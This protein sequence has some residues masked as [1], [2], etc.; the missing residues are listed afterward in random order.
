MA[1]PKPF[2]INVPQE[3]IDRLKQKLALADFPDE[4]DQSGWDLGSP[5]ADIKKLT[6]AW[7]G[8]DWRAAEKK[9]NEFPQFHTD[10]EVDGFGTLDIHFVHRK[11]EDKDAIPLLF[12]HGWPGSFIEVLKILPLLTKTPSSN[13][14]SFHVVAP[15]LPNYGFSQG[16][17]KRG[18]AI[19]HGDWGYLITRGIGRLYPENCM[20]SHFNMILAKSPDSEETP[21]KFDAAK[22]SDKEIQGLKRA[23]WFRQE[24]M[25]YNVEQ[26]TKPQ[27]LAYALQDSPVALLAWIYEKLH[28]WT[29]DY[30]WDVEEA[31]TWI[32][33]Y[34]FSR[35]GPAAPQRIY[36]EVG[37]TSADGPD[38]SKIC[39]YD[40]L[41][42]YNDKVPI[43]FT[44]S[45]R[46]LC[47]LP[48]SWAKTLGPVVF[49]Q[50]NEEGGHFYAYEKPELLV[51]DLKAMF[52]RDGETYKRIS[53]KYK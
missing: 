46:D 36:Y 45:P 31:L 47:I 20:A 4:L 35:A 48:S 38:P 27:T 49:E 43:G 5:L 15:S 21:L 28:D 22:Y 11:A 26:S 41:Q 29:D 3:K 37:H 52:S 7:Q 32:S 33:I 18:F 40:T 2:T 23:Q 51:R 19:A 12:V 44:Q 6:Q 13:D 9:L 14:V 1:S 50:R 42:E 25:G 10:I 24:G 30:P 17:S 39:T 53:K 8:H 16:V 34:Q